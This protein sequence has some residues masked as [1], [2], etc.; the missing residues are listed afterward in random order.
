MQELRLLQAACGWKVRDQSLLCK[1][2]AAVKAKCP[3]TGEEAHGS[4]AADSGFCSSQEELDR[5]VFLVFGKVGTGIRAK[6]KRSAREPPHNVH[7]CRKL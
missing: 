7:L 4:E 2:K 5:P 6:L 3:A 1:L